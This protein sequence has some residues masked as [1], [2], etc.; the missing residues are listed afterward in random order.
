M[1]VPLVIASIFEGHGE[2]EA[3]PILLRRI[4]NTLHPGLD[5]RTP[6]PIRVPRN[7]LLLP[8]ELERMIELA[9]RNI[10]GEGGI[11]VLL[12]SDDEC[13]AQRAPELAERAHTA[14][15]NV[16]SGVILAKCEFENWFLAGAESLRGQ[17]RLPNDLQS[18]EDPEAVR[19]AKEWLTQKMPRGSRYS[20][21]ID[22]AALASIVDLAAV[23]KASRSFRKLHK[24]VAR[25]CR[26]LSDR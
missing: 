24:E 1:T 23:H 9:A 17:R 8:K 5:L 21:T 13:P 3:V 10:G 4:V 19:G 12:D 22:Q 7:R 14:R 18:P 25:L 2:V 6:H 26:E 15:P 11:V 20:E 16:P